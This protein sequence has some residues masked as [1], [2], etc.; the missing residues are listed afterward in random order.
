MSAAAKRGWAPREMRMVSEYIAKYFPGSI[1]MSRVR[2]GAT[3]PD[4]LPADLSDAEK[5]MLTV[6]K[7]WADAIVITRT[8]LILI[9]GKILPDPGVISQLLLYKELLMH[10]PELQQYLDR[11]VEL[12]LVMAIED[13][14]VSKLARDQGIKVTI[15]TPDWI[16]EYVSTLAGRKQRPPLASAGGGGGA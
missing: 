4:L 13:P 14:L 7:R 5:R 9:E 1:T 6:W 2:L 16:G 11:D 3:S 10:T 15:F 8:R 12:Q